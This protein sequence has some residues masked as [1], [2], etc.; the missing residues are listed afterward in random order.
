MNADTPLGPGRP[1]NAETDRAVVETALDLLI[2]GGVEAVK[3]ETV[4]KR[5]GVT[6][7]T[8]YRRYPRREDL[9]IAAFLEGQRVHFERPV[10]ENPTLEDLVESIATALADRR[11]RALLRRMMVVP[12]DHP[13]LFAEFREGTGTRIREEAIRELLRR[14]ADERLF[15]QDADLETVQELFTA[16]ITAHLLIHPDNSS[17]EEIADYL[18][19]V[20]RTLGYRKES[21]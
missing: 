12:H 4:A 3:V 13:A 8:V 2:E 6:R 1:R 21:R 5:C 19:R 11:S 20:L 15:P 14:A 17:V 9:V 16:S 18:R 7:A 10:A